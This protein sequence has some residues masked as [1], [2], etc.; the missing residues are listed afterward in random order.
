M[1]LTPTGTPSDFT[2]TPPPA[3]ATLYWYPVNDLDEI[4]EFMRAQYEALYG[5]APVCDPTQKLKLWSDRSVPMGGSRTYSID[6]GDGTLGSLTLTAAQS[7]ALNFPGA[8]GWPVY[9]PTPNPATPTGQISTENGLA[10]AARRLSTLAQAVKYELLFG[11]TLASG[12]IGND[13]SKYVYGD[14]RRIYEV[15]VQGTPLV[16]GDLVA[17]ENSAGVGRPGT[18]T[19]ALVNNIFTPTWTPAPIPPDSTLG[20]VQCPIRALLKNADGTPQE[21]IVRPD[22]LTG[23]MIQNSANPKPFTTATPAAGATGTDLTP[24]I[25]QGV[26]AILTALIQ[27]TV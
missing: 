2:L 7:A 1:P 8:P 27:P 9:T 18:W 26:N 13:S 17:Q 10:I 3:P 25:L 19:T 21:T 24:R 16:V 6:N 12:E 22:P 11:G 23:W 14:S 15:V 4:P 5:L 20:V